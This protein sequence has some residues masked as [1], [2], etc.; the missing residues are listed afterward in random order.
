MNEYRGGGS[1]EESEAG[2][3]S[4]ANSSEDTHNS[5]EEEN[6]VTDPAWIPE[7]EQGQGAEDD[8]VEEQ[9]EVSRVVSR[10]EP[11]PVSSF[12]SI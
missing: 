4:S 6:H 5:A 3:S 8:E 11:F 12:F 10:V 2:E 9:V 1:D 7:E